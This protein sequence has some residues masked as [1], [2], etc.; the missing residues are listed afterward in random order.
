M[1]WRTTRLLASKG[2]R[3]FRVYCFAQIPITFLLPNIQLQFL[4]VSHTVKVLPRLSCVVVCCVL[5][6][7]KSYLFSGPP[8]GQRL[9]LMARAAGE[10]V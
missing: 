5:L 1:A 4:S 10:A 6:L 2:Y 3:Q 7:A 9:V 8:L